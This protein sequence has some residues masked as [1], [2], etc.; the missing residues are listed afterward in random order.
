MTD[1]LQNNRNGASIMAASALIWVLPLV[2]AIIAAPPAAAQTF[3]TLYAFTGGADGGGPWGTPLL[4]GGILFET[5]FYG[6]NPAANDAGTIFEFVVDTSTGAYLYQFGGQP[7]DGA[8]PM[9]GLVTDGQG[10]FFGTTNQGGSGL[11]G[12]L[13][14]ISG[15][16]ESVLNN[17]DGANGESPEGPLFIDADF[18]L[19]GTTSQGGQNDC[20]TVFLYTGGGTFVSLYSFGA[21]RNDGIGPSSSIVLHKGVVYGT[22]T[23]GGK[24]GWG[25]IYS[26]D[27]KTKSETVLYN[28][29]GKRD[30]GS[31]VGGMILTS[32]GALYGTTS[33]GGSA[34]GSKGNGVVFELTG[35][36]SANPTYRVVHKFAGT[37]G[38]QPSATLIADTQGNFYGTTFAGGAKGYGTVFELN[39]STKLLT[40][41]Y[42]FTNGT[43]GSYPYGGVTLDSSGNIYGAATRGGQYGWGTLFEIAP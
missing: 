34:R 21:D 38:S 18:D 11:R 2:S 15:P 1:K 13:Y 5:A 19:W 6:G 9:T 32:T 41:L 23:E 16:Y 4:S 8:E 3:K 12:T 10:D 36:A 25:T 29:Q 33:A 20:G 27:V 39:P 30:G 26:V 40:T 42:S 37:D 22:T 43:D 24:Y 14:E 17:F 28:F 35:I 7:N 31:P